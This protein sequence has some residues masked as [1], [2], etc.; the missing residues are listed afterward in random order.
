[1]TAKARTQHGHDTANDDVLVV[2][3][4]DAE[5]AVSAMVNNTAPAN[6]PMRAGEWPINSIRPSIDAKAMSVS[7]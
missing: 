6:R 7:G 2:V 4:T 1:M 5:Y 3:P